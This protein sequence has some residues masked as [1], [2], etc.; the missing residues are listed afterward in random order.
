MRKNQCGVI[1]E[2]RQSIEKLKLD[3]GA[4]KSF[5]AVDTGG[6][7]KDGLRGLG[8][9]PADV[10]TQAASGRRTGAQFQRVEPTARLLHLGAKSRPRFL[11]LLGEM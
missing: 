6:M 8:A 11:V 10:Y 9:N 3:S 5:D 2:R 1:G 4:G 7:K